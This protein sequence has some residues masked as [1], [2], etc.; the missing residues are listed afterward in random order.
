MNSSDF[1]GQDYFQCFLDSKHNDVVF[2]SIEQ[3]RTTDSHWH[4]IQ[5]EHGRVTEYL[6]GFAKVTGFVCSVEIARESKKIHYQ[7]VLVHVYGKRQNATKLIDDYATKIGLSGKHKQYGCLKGKMD[8]SLEDSIRYVLKDQG[9]DF[10]YT[11]FAK[12]YLDALKGQWLTKEQFKLQCK[13]QCKTRDGT[14]RKNYCQQLVDRF[15]KAYTLSVPLEDVEKWKQIIMT[16]LIDSIGKDKARLPNH[17]ILE[18]ARY[19]FVRYELLPKEEY[20]TR[21]LTQV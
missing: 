21:L 15:E 12:D 14:D 17:M 19:M 13:T 8:K 6:K 3:L 16:F 1:E 18:V 20:I 9:E 5:T 4:H 11:G 7:I 2:E 10:T